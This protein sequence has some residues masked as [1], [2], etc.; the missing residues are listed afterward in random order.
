MIPEIDLRNPAPSALHSACR[1]YGFFLLRGHTIDPTLIEAGLAATQQ[2]FE[3]PLE[4]KNRIRRSASN[5]WGYNDAELTKNKRDWKEILDI[6]PAET[7]GPLKGA[8]PQW[9]NIAGFQQTLCQL[10]DAMHETA[11]T[12]VT[13]IA[14]SLGA[15]ID[16]EYAFDCHTSFLRLN[17][18][19]KCQDPASDMTSLVPASG[20][21][22]IS[23][24]SDAGA[25]TVL[26]LD[27]LPGLQFYKDGRWVDACG[28]RG[29]VLIN[30]GDVVQVWSNDLYPAP[31]HRVLASTGA[32]RISI[33]YFLNPAYHYNYAPLSGEPQYRQINWGEFRSQR[34]AG[35]Y[36]DLGS[37]IQISDF[38][39][40][41]K[42]PANP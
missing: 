21:L 14:Q 7:E 6:G 13:Q 31:L 12:L 34:S 2:F 11:L 37:E 15:S 27:G 29:D 32:C 17:Y 41:G 20:E 23:H 4:A 35:D 33:P 3:S 39:I 38:A 22:G 5:C 18:Y 10:S 30:I 9:P 28:E 24:H 40:T 8:M 25:L 19:P 1:D 26:I 16:R 42:A 36:A